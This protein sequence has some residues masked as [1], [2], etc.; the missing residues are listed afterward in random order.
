VFL[1]IGALLAALS[2]SAVGQ[3]A[4]YCLLGVALAMPICMRIW[5]RRESRRTCL[6]S[7]AEN[8]TRYC[9]QM[10]REDALRTS[11][12]TKLVYLRQE[13]AEEEFP[14]ARIAKEAS[15]SLETAALLKKLAGKARIN[16]QGLM[17]DADRQLV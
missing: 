1:P 13:Y 17:R 15:V 16:K 6:A 8:E 9:E 12:Q 4:G 3:A 5:Q 14:V 11:R 7:V 2:K 10:C